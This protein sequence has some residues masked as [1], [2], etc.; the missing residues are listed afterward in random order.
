MPIK[1]GRKSLPI[2]AGRG[3][4]GGSSVD[5]D[6]ERDADRRQWLGLGIEASIRSALVD[7][8]E[9]PA[10]MCP[11]CDLG[12]A[13]RLPNG[14]LVHAVLQSRISRRPTESR[15]SRSQA[16]AVLAFSN[17]SA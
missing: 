12:H 15:G 13:R 3:A 16:I 14:G 9:V 7:V 6:R 2:P 11:T 4:H 5:G 10:H 1:C 8:V 17:Q